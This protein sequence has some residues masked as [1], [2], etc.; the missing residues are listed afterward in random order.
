VRKERI[1]ER[2][3]G[4]SAGRGLIGKAGG[5]WS[6]AAGV[7]AGQVAAFGPEAW[8]SRQHGPSLGPLGA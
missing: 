7:L 3:R 4:L 2:A 8:P 6:D 1:E 5:D